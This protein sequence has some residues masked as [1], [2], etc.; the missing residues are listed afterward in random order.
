MNFSLDDQAAFVDFVSSTSAVEPGESRALTG[1]LAGPEAPPTGNWT[2]I[3][4]SAGRTGLLDR[5]SQ[6]GAV[7]ADV[8]ESLQ[9]Q[10]APAYIEI[11]PVNSQISQLL[12]PMVV[13]VG[14]IKPTDAGVDV[15][16]IISHAIHHLKSH[17]PR[18]EELLNRLK[19]ARANGE[20]VAVTEDPTSHDI[21]QV[22]ALA[23][24]RASPALEP[25]GG[26]QE[27]TQLRAPLAAV[28]LSVAQQMFDLVNAKVCCPTSPTA[29]CIPF[30]YPDDGCWGRAHE[31]YRLMG[32]QGVACNKVW[33]Y[34]NLRAATTNNP[35]CQVSWGW[36]VAPTLQVKIGTRT[37]TYVIDPSL[38]PKPVTQAAWASV[39][40]DPQAQLAGSP[41]AVFYRAPSG[42]TQTDPSFTATNQ[43]LATYR[44]NLRL[45][46]VGADGPPPYLACVPAKTGVQFTGTLA[47]GATQSW[48]TFNWPAKWQVLWTVMPLTT[49]PGNV[50][51]KWRTRV[52][53]ASATMATYWIV[54]TNTTSATIRF[55]ARYDILSR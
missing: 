31:M 27:E 50:Q 33:I 39:Q 3:A 44:N 4:F 38:F 40:G 19:S 28:S 16:L 47:A 1:A 12:I 53:R 43:V 11:D 18:Y 21:I 49:C 6:R 52:E 35:H 26:V 55:E 10:N 24:P 46:S 22:T 30:D 25:P 23:G 15:E 32:N 13:G 14:E 42:A 5:S 29:P 2:R 8:L 54:V 9:Q 37:E 17:H 51:L 45:R 34:G 48:F 36:H 20:Q 41:G 7:W